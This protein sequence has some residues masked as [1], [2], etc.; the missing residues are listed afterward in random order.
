[1]AIEVKSNGHSILAVMVNMY[2]ECNSAKP[3][4]MALVE[5]EMST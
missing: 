1:V 2:I 5:K 3:G 4:S